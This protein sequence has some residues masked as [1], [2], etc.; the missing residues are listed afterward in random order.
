MSEF[1]DEFELYATDVQQQVLAR[2]ETEDESEFPEN[3]FTQMMT[4]ILS[5]AGELEEAELC[6]YRATGIQVSAWGVSGDDECLDLLVTLHTGEAP[7]RTIT[8]AEMTAHFKRLKDFAA[9]AMG[10]F[11]DK[12][13]ESSRAFD[14][15][16]RIYEVKENLTRIR[17]FLLTDGIVKADAPAATDMD[18]WQ[19]TY[20]VWDLE[21]F[22][23]LASSGRQQEPIEIDFE[24][25]TGAAIPCLAQP[26]AS[27]D[28]AAYLAIIPGT[29]LARLYGDY[30]SRLLERN[31]RS[32]LQ[33]RGKINMGIRRTILKEPHMFLAYNNGLSATAE[34]V[35]VVE[36]PG[37]GLGIKSVKDFQVVNGGQT[38]A[39]IFH[40]LKRDKADL[41]AL[42]VQAKLTVIS[43]G[44]SMNDIVP[45]ISEY[46]NSQNK[47][48]TADF[49]ANDV[50]HR[51][52][53]RLSRTIWAPAREGTQ[54]QT[55]WYYER[56]RGQYQ[57]AL[58]IERT[59]GRQKDF[60]TINPPAQLFTKTDLAKFI[61]T[62]AQ[63]PHI[64]SRGAQ[65]CFNDFRS[66]LEEHQEVEGQLGEHYFEAL[67]AKA[68]L[69]H[70]AERIIKTMGYAGYRAN[71]VTYTLARLSHDTKGRIDLSRI[72]REQRLSPSLEGAIADVS[73]HTWDHITTASGSG[74][75][76]QYC[77]QETC[78]KAFLE[79]PV[80]VPKM[81]ASE[82]KEANTDS[83]VAA[84]KDKR[85]ESVKKVMAITPDT[86]FDV[87][88]WGQRTGLING[89]DVQVATAIATDLGYGKQPSPKQ[90]TAG[91]KL[92]E[93]ARR[94][95]YR[96]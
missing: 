57:D 16:H 36:L 80:P 40:A 45:L 39:S 78:W 6:P 17:F 77:K 33:A 65:F 81:L 53:E 37:G 94:Q 69:F 22:Y 1:P 13:E 76:T 34:S 70:E 71:L 21:R 23:R 9:K 96:G 68:L 24:A 42:F 43:N 10:G 87:A 32:F 63:H 35:E 5:D 74:N 61:Q 2:S 19:V 20:Q 52:L 41:S 12:L 83:A 25:A 62:W 93:A 3:A 55:H 91:W 38:T 27:P 51:D 59:P 18:R 49:A 8:Q 72:W 48:Q 14:A 90:S 44:K 60:K 31:V 89:M 26:E 29:V 7:P 73:K 92:I 4:E 66:K 88:A 84:V 79:H 82:L 85:P 54:R 30:G 56:A 47:V 95:G 50:Y 11:C 64:V 15:A 86:W 75:V 58:A 28:Y 67:V 46:A